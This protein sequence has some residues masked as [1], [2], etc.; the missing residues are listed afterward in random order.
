MYALVRRGRAAQPT[1]AAAGTNNA[2]IGT[3]RLAKDSCAIDQGQATYPAT[4]ANTGTAKP[5]AS[6]LADLE[7]RA[8]AEGM[9]TVE[10]VALREMRVNKSGWVCALSV[11]GQL[12]VFLAGDLGSDSPWV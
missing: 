9:L 10:E 3:V 12:H 4:T 2:T 7:A 8:D 1:D 11:G 5:V 6:R